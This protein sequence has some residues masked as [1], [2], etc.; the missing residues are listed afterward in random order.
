MRTALPSLVVACV[1]AMPLAAQSRPPATPI[2]LAIVSTQSPTTQQPARPATITIEGCI[3]RHAITSTAPSSTPGAVGT[4]G[5]LSSSFVLTDVTKAIGT[6]GR[7]EPDAPKPTYR[8]DAEDSKLS[9]H[10]G[11]RVEVI[12]T[13]DEM[14]EKTS[15]LSD[16][17]AAKIAAAPKL[18]VESVRMIASN[19]GAAQ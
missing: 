14:A 16:A 1:C 7:A 11:H 19:C 15:G 5:S 13:L 17:D 3:Q 8:L 12:G 4:S 10:V 6:S 18:K 9:P 2:G